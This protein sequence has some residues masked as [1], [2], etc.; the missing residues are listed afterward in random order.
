MTTSDQLTQC[1]G[2]GFGN[3]KNEY[4]K[5]GVS[6]CGDYVAHQSDTPCDVIENPIVSEH[7]INKDNCTCRSEL[8][9]CGEFI[10]HKIS[11]PCPVTA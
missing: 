4:G 8:C 11:D 5:V 9:P 2:N 6:P 3:H 1:S 7:P 10:S